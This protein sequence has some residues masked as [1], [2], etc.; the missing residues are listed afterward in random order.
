MLS[1][2]I[3]RIKM[4]SRG[5]SHDIRATKQTN[6]EPLR[7]CVSKEEQG[8]MIRVQPG[9]YFKITSE[10]SLGCRQNK[11]KHIKGTVANMNEDPEMA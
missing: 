1:L 8:R 10:I 11:R 5:G 9:R 6:K 4:I 3:V 2:K 7:R